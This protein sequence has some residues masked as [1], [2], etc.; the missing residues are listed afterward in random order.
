MVDVSDRYAHASYR[1]EARCDKKGEG[2]SWQSFALSSLQYE[3]ELK[4]IRA[5]RDAAVDER[6]RLHEQNG[7]LRAQ[8]AEVR[9]EYVEWGRASMSAKERSRA[10]RARWGTSRHSGN[11]CVPRCARPRRCCV[12][13]ARNTIDSSPKPK[14]AIRHAWISAVPTFER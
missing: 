5:E 13:I 4:L 9:R 2:R 7:T 12:P 3:R 8:L 1:R 10:T 11:S 6:A 14:R